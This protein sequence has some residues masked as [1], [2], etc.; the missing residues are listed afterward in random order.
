MKSFI[1]SLKW[2]FIL[3]QKNNI[4]SISL[5][6]T[7]FYGLVLYFLK[8]LENMDKVV[9]FIVISD[10]ATIG[11]FFMG[12]MISTEKKSEVLSAL[13]V[14]P[15][16]TNNYLISKI[17]ALSVIGSVCALGIA[18]PVLGF[19]FNILLYSIGTFSV[20]VLSGLLGV[21]MITYT[22]EFLKFVLYSV[23]IFIL[24]ANLSLF[25]YIGLID[26]GIIKNLLPVQGALYL[27]VN[28]Y[29]PIPSIDEIIFGFVSVLIWLVIMYFM[30]FKLFKSKVINV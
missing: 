15:I 10:P 7:F 13:F 6:V 30:A 25:D 23:P 3:L 1:I 14:T 19:S 27:I 17:I 11:F 21:V 28:S 20:S 2:Q 9:A 18:I 16:N 29:S 24:Y 26:I 4:I 22:F 8:D 12:L 5:F